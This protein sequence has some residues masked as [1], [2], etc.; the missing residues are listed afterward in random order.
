V[1]RSVALSVVRSRRAGEGS[2]V[3]T[4]GSNIWEDRP[5]P[6]ISETRCPLPRGSTLIFDLFD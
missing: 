3:L 6:S 1:P 4:V 2:P 5:V